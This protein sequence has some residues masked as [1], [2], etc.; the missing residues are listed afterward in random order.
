MERPVPPAICA[1]QVRAAFE[2]VVMGRFA[3][4]ATGAQ[5]LEQH[6][7]LYTEKPSRLP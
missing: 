2:D 5:A 6:R 7:G 1:R 3:M 4:P